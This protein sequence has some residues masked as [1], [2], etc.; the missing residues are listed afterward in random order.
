MLVSR[1]EGK[2]DISEQRSAIIY[3]TYRHAIEAGDRNVYFVNGTDFFSTSERDLC[4]VD[5][6]HPNDLGFWLMA[7]TLEPL[8]RKILKEVDNT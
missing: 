5:G 6:C 2:A 1:P 4:T 3:E 7:N 8:L